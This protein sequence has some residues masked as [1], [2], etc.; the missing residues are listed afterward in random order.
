M[1]SSWIRGAAICALL[2][3]IIAAAQNESPATKTC[4]S[5]LTATDSTYAPGQV[6]SY[7][8][9][10]GESESTITILRVE[11]LP[12]IGIIVHVRIDGIRLRNCSGGGSPTTIQ[13]APFTKES[14]DKS[15]LRLE[16]KKVEL[17]DF[18]EGYS[19]WKANCG[20]VYTITIAEMLQAGELTLNGGKSCSQSQQPDPNGL[21]SEN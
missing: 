9:R 18:E 14:I 2:G 1:I 21:G 20:G 4:P 5:P 19:N 11:S 3:G 17:P 16:S 12:K 15:V 8:A 6:W 10:D 7:K 13:H